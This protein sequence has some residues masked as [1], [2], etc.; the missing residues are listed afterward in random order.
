VI[1]IRDISMMLSVIDMLL[2]YKIFLAER[3]KG[4]AILISLMNREA[5]EPCQG[6]VELRALH[7]FAFFHQFRA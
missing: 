2:L 4:H 5:I 7:V 1:L 3:S 6:I